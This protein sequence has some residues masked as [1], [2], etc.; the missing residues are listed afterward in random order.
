[1][2]FC[3]GINLWKFVRLRDFKSREFKRLWEI[4]KYSFPE[5]EKRDLE[6]EKKIMVKEE[7]FFCAAKENG[8]LIGLIEYWNLSNFVFVEHFT[9]KKDFEQRIWHKVDEA[10]L[11]SLPNPNAALF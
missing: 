6:D 4:Y 9:I 2:R 8:K 7:Y 10:F 1:M 5:G 3:K 11:N